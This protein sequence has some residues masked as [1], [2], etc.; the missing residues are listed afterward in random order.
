MPQ[1]R[2]ILPLAMP[3]FAIAG[4]L[5]GNAAMLF[6]AGALLFILVFAWVLGNQTVQAITHERSLHSRAFEGEKVALHLTLANR[7]GLALTGLTLT[8]WFHAHDMLPKR[9]FVARDPGPHRILT[10]VYHAFCLRHRGQYPMGPLQATFYDPLG[11]FPRTRTFQGAHYFTVLPRPLPM[12]QI[13]LNGRQTLLSAT[14]P[15]Q[16]TRGDSLK[17]YGVREYRPGDPLRFVHWKASAKLGELVVR[18]FESSV[19]SSITLFLDLERNNLAGLGAETTIEYGIRAAACI[20]AACIA[21]DHEIQCYGEGESPLILPM[22]RGEAHLSAFLEELALVKPKGKKSLPELVGQYIDRVPQGA[23]VFLIIAAVTDNLAD[24]A[25]AVALL[26]GRYAQVT[27]LIID[28]RSFVQHKQWQKDL[29][30]G[31]WPA[32][33]RMLVNMGVRVTRIEKGADLAA[34]LEGGAS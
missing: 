2:I 32:I 30:T 33:V 27:A 34:H 8:D 31:Q 5:Q 9:I 23:Q 25:K 11:L 14:T 6:M 7:S 4:L 18:Q 13:G 20:A 17:F 21:E 16:Q 24:Y 19:S 10:F 29:E 12:T 15:D 26:Q 3:I 22:G 28:S 1:A